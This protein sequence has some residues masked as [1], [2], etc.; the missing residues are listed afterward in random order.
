MD[1]RLIPRRQVPEATVQA[2]PTHVGGRS[3]SPSK[4]LTVRYWTWLKA[5]LADYVFGYAPVWVL[6]TLFG[7]LACITAPLGLLVGLLAGYGAA[8]FGGGVAI[9]LPL[10]VPVAAYA[11]HVG[12]RE[13]GDDKWQPR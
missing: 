12:R 5:E 11:K 9:A 1:E 8:G 2:G 3:G 4:P 7:A 6:L 13:R 10:T